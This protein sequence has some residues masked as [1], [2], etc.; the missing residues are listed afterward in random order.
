MSQHVEI[1]KS[2]R[3]VFTERAQKVGRIGATAL[4]CHIAGG[5]AMNEFGQTTESIGPVDVSVGLKLN[6]HS[7]WMLG[8]TGTTEAGIND[9]NTTFN[10][11]SVG[12]EIVIEP[13]NL[14][15]AMLRTRYL[16]SVNRANSEIPS[17]QAD[18][19][20]DIQHIRDD[21][22]TIAAKSGLYYGGGALAAGSLMLLSSERRRKR[23]GEALRSQQALGSL[24]AISV[25][26]G[27]SAVGFAQFDAEN[28]SAP[29]KSGAAAE[30]ELLAKSAGSLSSAN[31]KYLDNALS[32][33]TIADLIA[34]EA[35]DSSN[36]GEPALTVMVK[37]DEHNTDD[38]AL[39][40]I[41][42][43]RT[44]PD[45]IISLGDLTDFGT[46]DELNGLL[47][48]NMPYDNGDTPFYVLGGNH[49]S[50]RTMMALGKIKNT[51]AV[52][53]KRGEVEELSIGGLRVLAISAPEY[54]PDKSFDSSGVEEEYSVL[55]SEV[56]K[57]LESA[58]LNNTP[59]D[60]V[61]THNPELFTDI[62]RSLMSGL[63]AG[64]THKPAITTPKN[65]A[66]YANPGSDSAGGLRSMKSDSSRS[67][68]TLYFDKSCQ[69]MKID[70]VSLP[71]VGSA[72][73]ITLG[74]VR[75][76]A[77][78]PEKNTTE[79]CAQ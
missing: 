20:A 9:I 57:R 17:V 44:N 24:A 29:Q 41:E 43:E 30:A 27:T 47:F 61:M 23:V 40:A 59:F 79:R 49:D 13:E 22:V 4:L 66:W 28:F 5:A 34:R 33:L 1:K 3:E 11:H 36:D 12:P 38:S 39:V 70:K 67:Y 63:L 52:G 15:I 7:P 16:P 72:D 25:F 37:S 48:R 35:S 65:K 73:E 31:E 74:T 68:F 32:F 69:L 50:E 64:H 45:A 54:T 6:A 51:V 19:T 10:T 42:I 76:S 56:T 71:R 46:P 75:N 78:D 60:I 14:D 2:R 53:E 21:A 58:S 8:L 62:D 77:Y 26:V 55:R 18:I